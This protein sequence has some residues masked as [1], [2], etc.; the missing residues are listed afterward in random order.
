MI[1]S[2]L[3]SAL[4]QLAGLIFGAITLKILAIM[5]GPSGVGLFSLFRHLQQS[6]SLVASLGGQ[7]AIIQG[8]SSREEEQREVFQRH[9]CAVFVVLGLLLAIFM[10]CSASLI[11]EWMFEGGYTSSLRWLTISVLAG[12][13]LFFLRGILN[14]HLKFNEIAL[15]NAISGFGGCF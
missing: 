4:G 10:L 2:T 7:A 6:L 14:A 13:G 11:S 8:L 15:I 12:S 3:R 5:T 1:S 9:V